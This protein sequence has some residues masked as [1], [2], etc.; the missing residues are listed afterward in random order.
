MLQ[1]PGL[2]LLESEQRG[3]GV[4]TATEIDKGSLIEICPV[5]V[6]PPEQVATIHQTFLHDYYFLWPEPE[7]AACI[8]LG[9]GSLYNHSPQPNAEIAYDLESHQI[10]V[11]CIQ[12]IPEATEVLIDYNG[13]TKANLLWFEMS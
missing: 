3:R 5:I 7:G 1:I 9:F 2:Y 6:I 10:Q 12:T 11:R 8:A 13:G 4:F